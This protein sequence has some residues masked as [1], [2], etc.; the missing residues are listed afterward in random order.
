MKLRQPGLLK[1]VA[2]VAA[3]V[4][5]FLVGSMRIRYRSLGPE[6][7]PQRLGNKHRFIYATWHENMLLP[8]LHFGLPSLKPL[9]SQHADGDLIAETIR[10]LGMTAVRGSTTRGGVEGL[11]QMLRASQGYHLAVLPDGPRGPR[12]RV[13]SGLVYLASLTGLPIILVGVG[14]SRPWRMRSWDRFALPRPFSRGAMVSSKPIPVP[15]GLD[16]DQLELYRQLVEDTLTKVTQAAENWVESGK[17]PR[18]RS[19]GSGV[20]T[21]N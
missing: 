13:Q 5:R 3:V 18:I 10:H 15:P 14:Y 2:F 19:Q 8:T 16:R 7:R 11:R 17:W 12:R 20:S 6:V 4:L 9:I 1:I 21:A